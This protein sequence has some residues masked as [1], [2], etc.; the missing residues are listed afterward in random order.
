MQNVLIF[1][2]GPM[3]QEYFTVVKHLGCVP[4][5]VGRG[6][7]SAD[8]F[9]QKTGVK[10]LLG[11]VENNIDLIRSNKN[12]LAVIATNETN[13]DEIATKLISLGSRNILIEKPGGFTFE[14]IRA[15]NTLASKSEVK[16]AVAYNR[17]YYQSVR[18]ARDIIA[19][20]GGAET[21]H[22]DFTERSHVIKEIEK[23]DGVKEEWFLSNSTHVLDLAFFLCGKPDKIWA[24]VSGAMDWHPY[25]KVFHG[26]GSTQSGCA[27]TYNSNWGAPGGWSI[28]ITTNKRKLILAPLER[29]QVFDIGQNHQS[30]DKIDYTID[31]I[32]KPGIHDLIKDALEG[33]A[34][35]PSIQSQASNCLYYQTIRDGGNYVND[36]SFKS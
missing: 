9:Y 30:E 4:V 35:V 8:N 20:D 32:F 36:Q 1:G 7:R 6:D 22:F 28:S 29:L 27:F 19:A 14:S 25:G 11:G 5:V 2:A 18:H 24:K 21:L 16:I 15:L 3:A 12:C 10:P 31:Q 23:L 26:F 17:R 13:L 33:K 34:I